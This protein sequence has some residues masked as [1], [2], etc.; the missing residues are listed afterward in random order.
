MTAF[1]LG[2]PKGWKFFVELPPR[3]DNEA[4]TEKEWAIDLSEGVTF[5]GQHFSLPGGLSVKAAVQWLEESLLSVRLSLAA[6]LE[7]Q[8]ARCLKNAALAIS[9]DLMYLYYSRG[10][11][12]GKDTELRSDDGFM[13]VEIDNWGRTLN[14]SD[15]VWESLLMLLPIKLLCREDCAGLCQYCGADLN[16]GPCFC[17]SQEADPRFEVLRNALMNETGMNRNESE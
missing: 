8:C 1:V 10:L 6:S 9:D 7:G 16:E 15:Q 11:E 13:P 17:A 4:V 5:E 14:L 2:M 12:L 3:R